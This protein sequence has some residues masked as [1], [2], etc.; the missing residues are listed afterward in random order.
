MIGGYIAL[1][2]GTGLIM[3]ILG[4]CLGYKDCFEYLRSELEEYL[5]KTKQEATNEIK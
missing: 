1:T 3:F 4:Y 5:K 2:I